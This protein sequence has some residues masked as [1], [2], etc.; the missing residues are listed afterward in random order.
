MNKKPNLRKRL[1][2][3]EL[4][5]LSPFAAK[6]LKSK[7]RLRNEKPH[8]FLTCFQVDRD[9]IINSEAFRKL[10]HKTQVFLS[11]LE[12]YFRTRLTHTL[13]VSQIS[14]TIGKVLALNED[15][16]EA[17]ALGHDLGHTP[18]GHIGEKALNRIAEHGFAHNRQSVRIINNLEGKNGINL[19]YE[20]QDGILKHS[21]GSSD[22]PLIIGQLDKNNTLEGAVVRISDSI[23]YINHDIDDAI[24]SGLIKPD[25][26]PKKA[27]GILGNS[28]RKR[29]EIMINDIIMNSLG[30]DYIAWSSK[31]RTGSNIL[32]DFLYKKV[33]PRPEIQFEMDKANKVL[34]EIFYY[35]KENP[36]KFKKQHKQFRKEFSIDENLCDYISSLSDDEIIAMYEKIFIPEKWIRL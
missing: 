14:R 8:P 28:Y 24:V 13:A 21:K 23:A 35:F 15:L 5:I 1:E 17:I 9:R 12:D 25:D 3:L 33:Y 31:I 30:K 19:T 32:K 29:L 10:K 34:E 6:S 27:R 7:G 11:P 36:E 22:L 18:F 20:V 16:I 2:K 26:I 4:E